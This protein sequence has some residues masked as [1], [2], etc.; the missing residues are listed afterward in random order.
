MNRL[1]I[2]AALLYTFSQQIIAQ[3]GTNSPYSQYG[4]GVLSDQSQGLSRGMNGVGLG[5]RSNTNVNTLNPAS[6]S[7]VDSLTM[8][9]DVGLSAQ[10]T[11]FKE[12]GRNINANNSNFEYAVA[13]FRAMPKLG[14][15]LG[16]LPYSNV[17]YNYYSS[18]TIPA[19]SGDVA[20]TTTYE[21][22]SGSGGLH[23]AFVGFG[24][25]IINNLSIG[26]NIS[27]LWGTYD[28][29]IVSSASDTYVNTVT[30]NYTA[31]ISSYKLD[32][33]LQYEYLIDPK[34]AIVLGA[35]YGL[36]HSLNADPSVVTTN[37]NSSTGVSTETPQSLSNALSIPHSFALGATWVHNNK[38][39]L[40][41]DYS[42]QKWGDVDFPEIDNSQGD[43]YV[44][45]KGLLNDRQK[46][47]IGVDYVPNSLSNRFFQRLHY[48]FGASYAT[49]YIDVN[50]K[51]GPKEYSVSLGF[52]V[53]VFKNR[54]RPSMLNISG[55]WV[56]SSATGLI[57]EN[58][59]RINIGL[60]FN[61]RWFEK[62][63]VE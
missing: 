10:V 52:G 22:H 42:L 58:M 61:E 45:K 47:N 23:Q 4:L 30:R 27:Y 56:R 31:T 59:F 9:F 57:E 14:V 43:A 11:N 8:I 20:P 62:W 39:T 38:L 16:L 54:T 46:I 2:C 21:T 50:G 41:L 3:S 28:R 13:M 37:S 36:G 7:A 40:G 32:F 33:G 12:S 55:Q 6:Y 19:T 5:L 18:S 24:W 17:G 15:S 60:T 29:S 34:N 1:L 63:K 51:E 35:T 49:P 53:P 26:A 25:E 48:R 44:L